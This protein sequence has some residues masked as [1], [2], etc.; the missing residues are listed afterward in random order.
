MNRS[1]EVGVLLFEHSVCTGCSFYCVLEHG[2]CHGI[3]WLM[4]GILSSR[5]DKIH[6]VIAFD[7]K[8][9]DCNWYS[10]VCVFIIEII[11]LSSVVLSMQ[12]AK[13]H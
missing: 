6:P 7:S 4:Q 8:S 5:H 10:T 12:I 1:S 3:S 11:V 2:N 9:R 13:F